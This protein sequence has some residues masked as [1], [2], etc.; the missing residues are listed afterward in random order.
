MNLQSITQRHFFVVKKTENR[1]MVNNGAVLNAFVAAETLS[2]AFMKEY[3][4][5]V[6][7]LISKVKE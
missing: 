2:V 3:S 6:A 1:N 7:D 5:V 4:D